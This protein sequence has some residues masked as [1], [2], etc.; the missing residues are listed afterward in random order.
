MPDAPTF[1][2]TTGEQCR[3][4]NLSKTGWGV[5]SL[6]FLGGLSILCGMGYLLTQLMPL[7]PSAL[8]P[9]APAAR[10]S[11]ASPF[12]T[13][14]PS[15]SPTPD[16]F[17]PTSTPVILLV[18]EVTPTKEPTPTLVPAEATLRA[19]QATATA[20]AMP[21]TC[22]RTTVTPGTPEV[23]FWMSVLPTP[24]PMPTLPPCETPVP[25]MRCLKEG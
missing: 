15:P 16:P 2:T 6:L 5:Q 11:F 12:P 22:E 23:C 8:P 3:C 19:G 25:A 9:T 4:Q 17:A 24:S 13:E 21:I 20:A 18:I 1:D 7:Q 10:T 14:T